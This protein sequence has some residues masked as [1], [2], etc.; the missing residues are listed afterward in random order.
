MYG[1]SSVRKQLI[2]TNDFLWKN[3]LLWILISEQKFILLFFFPKSP[4]H[5]SKEAL[6]YFVS[7]LPFLSSAVLSPIFFPF[8]SLV[9]WVGPVC[10]GFAQVGFDPSS[11]SF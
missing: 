7:K 11:T 4:L 1:Q 6:S 2:K 8:A 9:H 5:Y 3:I 10:V